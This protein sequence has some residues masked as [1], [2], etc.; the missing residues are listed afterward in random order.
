M[1]PPKVNKSIHFVRFSVKSLKHLFKVLKL[2]CRF[3]DESL[4]NLKLHVLFQLFSFVNF[5]GTT[6][7]Q[8]EGDV[9]E[10]VRDHWC[11]V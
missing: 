11:L 7:I 10:A 4:V 2:P 3:S 6:E 5:N 1:R 9:G 8:N